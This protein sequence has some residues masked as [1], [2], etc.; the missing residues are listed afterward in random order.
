MTSYCD[1]KVST[2]S[3]GIHGVT[4]IGAFQNYLITF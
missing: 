2:V 3:F 1:K 4:S